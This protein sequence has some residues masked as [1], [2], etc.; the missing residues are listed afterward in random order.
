MPFSIDPVQEFVCFVG[1][2]SENLDVDI[3]A[4][5][6]DA[7]VMEMGWG[8]IALGVKRRSGKKSSFR[9][10][11]ASVLCGSGHLLKVVLFNVAQFLT[12]AW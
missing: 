3:S 10:W 7:K 11:H 4:F 1:D 8:S 2:K 9:V 6:F 5:L 12:L